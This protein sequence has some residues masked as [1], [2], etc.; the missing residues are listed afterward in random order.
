MTEPF[1]AA[2]DLFLEG[3]RLHEQ[4]RFDEAEQRFVASLALLPGRV[5]T[6]VNL[7]STRLQLGRPQ[8]ALEALDQ[9]L[10]AAD[11]Q[12]ADA[13]SYRAIA[14]TQLNRD[15]D[16]ADAFE[17]ALAIDP[18]ATATRWQH[19]LTL[20]RV[21]RHADALRA[22]DTL[23]QDTPSDGAAWTLHGQTLQLLDRHAEA[24]SSYRR[25][26]EWAPGL[27]DAWTHMG[28]LL[29]DLGQRD[30]AAAAFERALAGGADAALQRYFIAALQ[31]AGA[32]PQSP[33]AYVRALF[34]SYASDFDDHLVDTLHY[35]AHEAVVQ[36]A[37]ASGRTPF[38]SAL[39]LGC[40]TGLC[41][42]LLR[43]MVTRLDGV[44][45]SPTMLRLAASRA[46]YDRLAEADVA[47]HLQATPERYALVAAA[48]VFI[49]IGDLEAVFAGVRRVLQPR[50]VFVFSVEA[51]RDDLAYELRESLRYA[52]GE[53]ALR[54]LA[55]SHA[56]DL[57]D[58]RRETLREEQGA[59]IAGLVVCLGRRD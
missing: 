26:T 44:D 15:A 16:A 34:D 56:F 53:T 41:G 3:V 8:D 42:A 12:P 37:A 6:L 46:I 43:T 14:C 28:L 24:L 20:H 2:R 7:G 52:H 58:L 51:A 40:G 45:L 59:A 50:G 32:P 33:P 55:R 48:D 27:A 17:R 36:A 54:A 30:V 25:A 10:A 5:S 49:Y 19:A 29:K 13:W 39:D 35:R 47:A 21:R 38:A 18:G 23:L 9:A 11:P 1:D 22:L 57:L 31:H 4:R